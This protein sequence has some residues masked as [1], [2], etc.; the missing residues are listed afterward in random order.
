[1]PTF[2][3]P[4]ITGRRYKH[5]KVMP[6]D[7]GAVTDSWEYED[8]GMDYNRRTSSPPYRWRIVYG[9][10]TAA[11][12]ATFTAFWE[13]VGTDVTFD[14][15]DRA[16]TTHTNNVRVESYEET[17]EDHK[18]WKNFVTFILVKHP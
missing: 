7:F 6:R 8:G 10:L 13:S 4:A 14:F 1:M 15:T 9:P 2:P 3:T 18:S 12:L 17:H 16:G 11:Q 5:Y